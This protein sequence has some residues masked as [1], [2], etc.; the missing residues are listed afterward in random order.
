MRKA[1][2]GVVSLGI[3]VAVLQTWA[4]APQGQYS[5]PSQF[6]LAKP[7]QP[8]AGTPF[9]EAQRIFDRHVQE[10]HNL[11]GTI[12]VNFTAEGLVVRTANPETLPP[13][14]EGLPVFAIAPV[15]PDAVGALQRGLPSRPSLPPQPEPAPHPEPPHVVEHPPLP[16]C[17]SGMHRESGE[18]RCRFD[19]P[20]VDTGQE[21]ILNP[22]PP[23]VI[24][25]KPGKVREQA[26]A[27]PQEF[28]EVEG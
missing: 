18:V 15:D 8:I 20:P 2:I 28:K 26:S 25:L 9:D 14:V 13:A 22:P 7:G 1:V 19:T 4:Q 12:S 3:L 5:D 21:L 24:V 16:D 17:P 6:H 27:C 10:L 23:G 11:P